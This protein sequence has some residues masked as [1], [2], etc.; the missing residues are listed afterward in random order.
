RQEEGVGLAIEV[1]GA[2][3][4]AC[5]VDPSGTQEMP[6]TCR[7]NQGIN[8]SHYASAIVVDESASKWLRRVDRIPRIAHH[9]T[10]V[11]DR[12][13]HAI[14]IARQSPDVQ[15]NASG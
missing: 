2:D 12:K 4:L 9:P 5:V 7:V 15:H 11:V 14:L 6:A 13:R 3:D 10:M 1:A 8:V